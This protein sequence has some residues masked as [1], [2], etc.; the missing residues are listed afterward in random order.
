[1]K[2]E[3]KIVAVSDT[4]GYH[5]DVDVPYGD[6]F[7]HAGD[8]M[9]CGYKFNEVKDFAQW[10]TS[11]PHPN[12][13]LVAGNH[14]RLFEGKDKNKCLLEFTNKPQQGNFH[15]LEDSGVSI[16]GWNFWGSPVQPWFFNWAFNRN[17]GD[18]IKKHWD[19]I[20]LN[21]DILITHGPPYGI[22]DQAIP[23]PLKRSDK[24]IIPASEHCGCEDLLDKV[25]QVNPELNIFG[26]IHGG[27]GM[28]PATPQDQR[29]FKEGYKTHFDNVSFCDEQYNPTGNC[30]THWFCARDDEGK[31]L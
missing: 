5:R 28:Y 26:H 29:D 12:K 30:H 18:D 25:R 27:R 6:V 2:E 3:I 13:I 11:L 20:P 23:H 8:L 16:K 4:H 14:D 9:T 19:K 22:G 31:T 17:R 15:Y 7:I 24:F 10:F 21:T 1:M